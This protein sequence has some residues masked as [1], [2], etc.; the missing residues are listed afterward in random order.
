MK[1]FERD[2]GPETRDASR[3]A[4]VDFN[5]CDFKECRSDIGESLARIDPLK[6]LASTKKRRCARIDGSPLWRI[7]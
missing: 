6:A 3:G 4:A 2:V 1:A 7:R 5:H